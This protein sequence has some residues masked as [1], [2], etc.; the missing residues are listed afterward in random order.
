[1]S[2]VLFLCILNI[3]TILVS[4]FFLSFT[5]SEYEISFVKIEST[6]VIKKIYAR[7]KDRPLLCRS[8]RRDYTI[9]LYNNTNFTTTSIGGRFRAISQSPARC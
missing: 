7:S 9:I 8:K 2:A 3:W 1:M 4:L 5:R 6:R